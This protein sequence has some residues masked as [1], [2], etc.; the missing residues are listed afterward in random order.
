MVNHRYGAGLQDFAALFQSGTVSDLTDAELLG[1]FA[2]HINE[3]AEPAF[4][5][6]LQRHGP[7]VLRVC[8]SVLR[9]EHDAQDAF[10]AT[11]LILVRRAGAIRNRESIGSWL[12]GVALR[13]SSRARIAMARRRK[14]ETR[15]ALTADQQSDDERCLP[16]LAAALHEELGRLPEG[17]RAAV[18]L[19]YLEGQTCEAAARQLGWPVGT[20]K[21][22]LARGKERLLGRLIRRG[23]GADRSSK[24]WP[25]PAAALP[26]EMVSRTARMM[27]RFA[28]RESTDG[29]ASSTAFSW[30]VI[31]S[32]T[33]QMTR[34]LM[35]AILGIVGLV[36][37]G[38][39]VLALQKPPA[40]EPAALAKSPAQKPGSVKPAAPE[41]KF[42][43]ISVRVV[44]TRNRG[45]SNVEITAVD[46]DSAP[47][48]RRY[49]TGADG[50]VV[51]PVDHLIETVE[52]ESRPDDRT[53]GWSRWR[54]TE[55]RPHGT[56][57]D[58]VTL[59]L[60]PL[61][62]RVEGTI[63]N[64]R[65][66][67]IPDVLVRAHQLSHE[68]NNE[69]GN[70]TS[71]RAA[72][73]DE[74]GRYVF[75]LPADTI[76]HLSARHARY[77]G[78][79]F[80][81]HSEDRA[82]EPVTLEDG[83]GIAGT[84]TDSTTGKP[85]GDARV[86]AQTIELGTKVPLGGGWGEATSDSDGHFQVGGLAPGVY[87]LLFA[88]S[89]KGRRFTARAVEGVRVKAGEDSRADLV[90]I[91]G[92]RLC[93]TA[94]HINDN[95]PMAGAPV[96]CY[97][98]ARPRS[99]AACQGAYTDEQG[100]FEHFVP[101]GQALVYIALPGLLGKSHRKVLTIPTDRD[102]EP[103]RLERNSDPT[104]AGSR[105]AVRIVECQAHVRVNAGDANVPSQ[106]KARTLS[107][108]VFDEN[109]SA[110]AGV[111]VYCNGKTFVAS[112]TDRLGVFRLKA[113]PAGQFQL[114]LHKEGYG[115]SWARI[116]PDAW[117]VDVTLP[118]RSDPQD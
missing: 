23:F 77:V 91:E 84:V 61:N 118:R 63:R 59:M 30:A 109:G 42:E 103:V 21:S 113:L 79:S 13:V 39:A 19:C 102:P 5:A 14:H 48:G 8:R 28:C 106:D 72:V 117:E 6:L 38:A 111:R 78:P 50:R 94:I 76:V 1:R 116:A 68:A 45:V 99:G 40:A 34:L 18:V 60:L 112:A 54:G 108:R 86:A 105:K 98:T 85:V 89:P 104:A 12:Y 70:G 90:L 3:S 87:N 58:P 25:D 35:I 27:L 114:S 7:M 57:N 82:V 20:V 93:G 75:D 51:V 88:S 66:K 96:F 37:T 10:Q 97:S 74:A 41:K 64:S 44:D 43:M 62:H 47:D 107:G 110:L 49:R 71:L 92:R 67:P 33:M 31:A 15:V 101:P 9:D 24:T 52:F 80:A 2:D 17:Y 16:E 69:F 65:G 81:V 100:R 115:W 4:A 95:T 83:G 11:F 22:R 73:T 26:A 36:A 32:R 55:L 29:L 56:E 53:L 46:R